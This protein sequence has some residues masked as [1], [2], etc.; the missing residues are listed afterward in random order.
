MEK[1]GRPLRKQAA[2]EKILREMRRVGD[3]KAAVLSTTDG[4]SLASAPADYE[5]E[6]AAAIVALLNKV[7]GQAR[8]QLNLA[9]VDELSLVGDDRTRLACRYFSVDGQDLVLA[10]LVPRDHSYRRL[11]NRAIRALRTVW[12][13]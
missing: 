3:F 2:F 13:S 9:Q 4:L 8:Q 11:T 6:M 10:V 7:A 1:A 5:D 12:S